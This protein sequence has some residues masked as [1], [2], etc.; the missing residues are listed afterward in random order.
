M[1]T[2]VKLRTSRLGKYHSE[3]T[4]QKI[5]KAN[6]KLKTIFQIEQSKTYHFLHRKR[7]LERDNYT[8]QVCGFTD[9]EIMEVDHILPMKIYPKLQTRFSNLMTM[10]PNCHR[11]KTIK[12]S[13]LYKWRNWRKNK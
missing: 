7:I 3:K 8:C 11:R 13:K 10:C 12:D 6:T 1:K 4:K 2:R 5:S 9:S